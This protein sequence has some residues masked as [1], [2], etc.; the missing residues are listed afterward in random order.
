MADDIKYYDRLRGI[1]RR[2]PE[3]YAKMLG[4]VAH[5]NFE[6]LSQIMTDAG[7]YEDYSEATLS[8]FPSILEE[9]VAKLP[10][11][12]DAADQRRAERK[13]TLRIIIG[14]GTE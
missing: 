1:E 4:A 5:N 9:M 2:D 10:E 7:L 6:L 14:S 11:A 12:K 13:A 3:L 8:A